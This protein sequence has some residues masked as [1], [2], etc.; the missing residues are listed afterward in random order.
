MARAKFCFTTRMVRRAAI[1]AFE[2]LRAEQNA[3]GKTVAKAPK[4]EK[5][6]LV[7]QAQELAAQV[8]AGQQAVADAEAAFDQMK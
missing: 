3:F 1:T 8:K 4:D 6:A 5:A 7:A 2:A